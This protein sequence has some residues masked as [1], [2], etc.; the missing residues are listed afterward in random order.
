MQPFSDGCDSPGVGDIP[1]LFDAFVL[2]VD[3]TL[4]RL[5]VVV[6]FN[7]A[8]SVGDWHHVEGFEVEVTVQAH[9]IL[10]EN[11]VHYLEQLLDS[12]IQSEVFPALDQQVVVSLVA[13]VNGDAFRASI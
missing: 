8:E 11:L 4:E 1:A 5:C 2:A 13:P 10:L 6:P 9:G 3:Q 12:L 7:A